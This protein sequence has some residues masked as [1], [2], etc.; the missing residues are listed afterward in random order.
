ML[1][2]ALKDRVIQSLQCRRPLGIMQFVNALQF[3]GELA[4][5]LKLPPPVQAAKESRAPQ[6]QFISLLRDG[7][8]TADICEPFVMIAEVGWSHCGHRNLSR[9]LE[10]LVAPAF[11]VK[12]NG[13]LFKTLLEI[14]LAVLQRFHAPLQQKIALLQTPRACVRPPSRNLLRLRW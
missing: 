14:L 8:L 9:T 4:W 6:G 3:L 7:N 2:Q 5:K 1:C 10:R 11:L 13:R 12:Q